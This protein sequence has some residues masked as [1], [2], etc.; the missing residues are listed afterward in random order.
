MP[1]KPQKA[2]K[3]LNS[4][5]ANVVKRVPFTIKLSYGATG[6]KQTLTGGMDTGSKMVGCAVIGFGKVVYQ[7]QIALRQDVSKKRQAF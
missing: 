6:Y 1:C 4:G 3:L 2:R 5:K 7:S